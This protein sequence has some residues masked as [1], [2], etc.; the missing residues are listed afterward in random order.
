MHMLKMI[1]EISDRGG[2]MLWDRKVGSGYTQQQRP[3]WAVFKCL[4]ET[5]M[6]EQQELQQGPW[7][8]SVG[9]RP[10]RAQKENHLSLG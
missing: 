10:G 5:E 2:M 1:H 8:M 6:N 7:C 3:W 9:Q 4:K